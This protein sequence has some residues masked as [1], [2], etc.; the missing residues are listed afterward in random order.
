MTSCK[1]AGLVLVS[2]GRIIDFVEMVGMKLGSDDR[3]YKVP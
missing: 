2:F 3:G 1:S